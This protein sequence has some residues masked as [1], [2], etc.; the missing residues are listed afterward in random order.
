MRSA[1]WRSLARVYSGWWIVRATSSD[2]ATSTEVASIGI[3]RSYDG[4]PVAR[5]RLKSVLPGDKIEIRRT[6]SIH[7]FSHRARLP[8]VPEEREEGEEQVS[9]QIGTSSKQNTIAFG[10]PRWRVELA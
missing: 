4:S 2:Q 7:T 3:R 10:P 1:V 5:N 9:G 8:R 6:D